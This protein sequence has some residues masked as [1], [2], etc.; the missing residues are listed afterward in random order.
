MSVRC[1]RSAI[2]CGCV[3]TAWTIDR[4]VVAA[5]PI[6]IAG[7][8]SVD[9]LRG[10]LRKMAATFA[11]VSGVG[12]DQFDAMTQQ[13]LGA[14][15]EQL[16]G[17]NLDQPL[18][19]YVPSDSDASGLGLVWLLPVSDE[20]TFVKTLNGL[21]AKTVSQGPGLYKV[22][23]M[24]PTGPVSDGFLRFA[25]DYA[26]FTNQGADQVADDALPDPSDILAE[27]GK[28]DAWVM[29]FPS[30]MSDEQRLAAKEAIVARAQTMLPG[31]GPAGAGNL[32][33]A[34]MA[35]RQAS[36]KRLEESVDEFLDGAEI[37]A[38]RVN[39]DE[40]A[41][42]LDVDVRLLARDESKWSERIEHFRA[43]NSRFASLASEDSFLTII[44]GDGFYHSEISAPAEQLPFPGMEQAIKVINDQVLDVPGGA[45]IDARR[46]GNAFT[47]L[48][49]QAI[50]D[51]PA[52]DKMLRGLVPLAGPQFGP[53]IELGAK[54][55]RNGGVVHK[56]KL[57]QM[58]MMAPPAA[59][60]L[61]TNP[62][63]LAIE[64]DAVLLVIG[65]KSEA[66]MDKAL[67][68][69]LS[70]KPSPMFS[71]N[72]DPAALMGVAASFMS[73]PG[74]AKPPSSHDAITMTMT[75][76]RFFDTKLHIDLKQLAQAAEIAKS[77]RMAPGGPAGGFPGQ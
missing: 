32:A 75:G 24:L 1:I 64:P 21:G 28:A 34:I 36:I 62:I 67:A 73:G 60:P 77:L 46:S 26:Y 63:V 20:P 29:A 38:L 43:S 23:G 76:E 66:A 51:G 52:L 68:A 33:A 37:A 30:R 49:A 6:L 58:A 25:N 47:L 22:D 72:V 61:L 53:M 8:K 14:D 27:A 3:L 42:T 45:L 11:T 9:N 50:K 4:T 44:H 55:T 31:M 40:S 65:D 57:A 48:L 17:L 16:A 69:D 15:D 56:V 71:A 35:N 19:V 54:K 10:D 7:I 41:D 2:L 18:G 70:L 12:A 5:E 74:A 13:I 59:K 39:L